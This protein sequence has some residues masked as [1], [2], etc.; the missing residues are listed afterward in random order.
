MTHRGPFQPLPFH[1]SNTLSGNCKL[2]TSWMQGQHPCP[3]RFF[4]SYLSSLPPWLWR[5]QRFFHFLTWKKRIEYTCNCCFSFLD[6]L[7]IK[8]RPYV[9][10]KKVRKIT[11][12]SNAWKSNPKSR[13]TLINLYFQSL[14]GFLQQYVE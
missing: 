2:W 11:R 5:F 7:W 9:R 6:W 14:R 3:P 8:Y 12:Y 1:E 4:L 10:N 13:T